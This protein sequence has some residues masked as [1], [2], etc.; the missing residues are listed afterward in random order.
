[1][2]DDK[3]KWQENYTKFAVTL[4]ND[5]DKDIIDEA[6]RRK[7]KYNV[8]TASTFRRWVRLGYEVDKQNE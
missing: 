4:N 1:M 6:K 8:T 2:A 7:D 3:Y 5:K